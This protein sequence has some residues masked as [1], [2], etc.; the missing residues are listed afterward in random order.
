MA[1]LNCSAKKPN[2][3]GATKMPKLQVA[4]CEPMIDCE[5]SLPKL[6]GVINVKLGKVGPL[7]KPIMKSATAFIITGIGNAIRRT[8]APTIQ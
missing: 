2:S 8:Q 4:I 6:I 5:T 3:A 1:V 7:P